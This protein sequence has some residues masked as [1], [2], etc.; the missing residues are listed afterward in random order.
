MTKSCF[1]CHIAV[2]T[3]IL[4]FGSSKICLIEHSN[5]ALTWK[6]QLCSWFRYSSG[7]SLHKEDL[8][9][10]FAREKATLIEHRIGLS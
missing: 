3:A 7:W 1:V 5:R 4:F 2:F 8:F 6:R 9:V 10:E